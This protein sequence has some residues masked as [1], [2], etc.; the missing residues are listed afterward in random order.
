MVISST[1]DINLPSLAEELRNQYKCH[2]ILLYGSFARGDVHPQ[3]DVDILCIGSEGPATTDTRSWHGHT[4]DAWIYP[5]S[6]FSEITKWI[7]L[8]ESVVLWSNSDWVTL[9]LQQITETFQRGPTPLVM[10]EKLHQIHWLRKMLERI[11][12]EDTEAHYRRHWL[13]MDLLPTYFSLRDR[14]YLGPKRA[15]RWLAEYEPP[16]YRC[17]QQI[18]HPA[19][20]TSVLVAEINWIIE[21][22]ISN[23]FAS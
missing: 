3:S 1:T 4:L 6:D 8:N 22:I 18:F 7:Y 23:P 13:L 16:I 2:T 17:F 12:R 5:E 19:C 20:S 15:L 11:Q 10:Q 21:Q 14:W 9:F